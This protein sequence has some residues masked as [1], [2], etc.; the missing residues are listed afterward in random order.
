M[1]AGRCF[2]LLV[3]THLHWGQSSLAS[4]EGWREKSVTEANASA[5]AATAIA[6]QYCRTAGASEVIDEAAARRSLEVGSGWRDLILR[7]SDR[8]RQAEETGEWSLDDTLD[9]GFFVREALIVV[10]ALIL[11]VFWLL[12][13]WFVHCPCCCR[14]LCCCCQRK[15]ATGKVFK[16]SAWLLFSALGIAGVVL[17]SRALTGAT[18]TEDGVLGFRCASSTFV[19]DVLGDPRSGFL[20]GRSTLVNLTELLRNGSFFSRNLTAILDRT[21]AIVSTAGLADGLL[22]AL[23]ANMADPV[24]REPVDSSGATLYHECQVCGPLMGLLTETSDLLGASAGMQMRALRS[25]A[26][27]FQSEAPV[28]LQ[29]VLRQA[30]E[31]SDMAMATIVEDYWKTL[32]GYDLRDLGQFLDH[33]LPFLP[34]VVLAPHAYYFVLMM[35][36]GVGLSVWSVKDRKGEKPDH[37]CVRFCTGRAADCA[38]WHAIC[39]LIISGV[40]VTVAVVGSGICLLVIDTDRENGANL[41]LASC[42][43]RD[44][45]N[46]CHRYVEIS[47]SMLSCLTTTSPNTSIL[48]FIE[49]P[50]LNR[51]VKHELTAAMDPILLQMHEVA[52]SGTDKLAENPKVTDLLAM[53]DVLDLKA[54]YLPTE[55]KISGSPFEA[56]AADIPGLG[57]EGQN[58][59]RAYLANSVSC[60][61]V[62]LS[63]SLKALGN[64]SVPGID[65]MVSDGFSGVPPLATYMDALSYSCPTITSHVCTAGPTHQACDVSVAFVNNI[66]QTVAK[67][68][69]FRCSYLLQ[70]HS[71]VQSASES[72][73]DGEA[74]KVWKACRIA[75]FEALLK[76]AARDLRAV[77]RRLDEISERLKGDFIELKDM[78]RREVADPL[79]AFQHSNSCRIHHNNF[80]AMSSNLC[81]RGMY[82]LNM[83][84]TSFTMS[85][86]MSLCLGLILLTAWKISRDNADTH[87]PSVVVAASV[88]EDLPLF[89]NA[90]VATSSRSG[91]DHFRI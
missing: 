17:A 41:L 80:K 27:V 69:V 60:L 21:S 29:K 8:A 59:F 91:E 83:I 14:F 57:D 39:L 65:A 47:G 9:P 35:F 73:S 75:E 67:D 12:A 20:A 28:H 13:S 46:D 4:Y 58:P 31:A 84:L 64:R 33:L 34:L 71:G 82:G 50:P 25:Q 77:F 42:G 22:A 79:A 66:K 40:A 45:E 68:A 2:P 11:C 72:F 24:N 49:V 3:L 85:G 76:G 70:G 15:W 1:P 54:L 53:I 26:E 19:K 43:P 37:C 55:S 86:L 81:Y 90:A 10:L 61:N 56:M 32:R 63:S 74:S 18:Y 16:G 48:D 5:A 7:L 87:K 52:A 36:A 44:S 30:L 6:S 78:V 88:E 62:T 89:R 51:T 23:I 38:C